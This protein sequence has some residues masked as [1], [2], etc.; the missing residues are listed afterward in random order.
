MDNYLEMGG[1]TYHKLDG[2]DKYVKGSSKAAW[3]VTELTD[4]TC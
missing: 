3:V 1:K 4:S 2:V